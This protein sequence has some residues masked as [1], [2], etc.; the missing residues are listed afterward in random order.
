MTDNPEI[1]S[2]NP[3]ITKILKHFP[4]YMGDIL[5][6]EACSNRMRNVKAKWQSVRMNTPIENMKI[7]KIRGCRYIVGVKLKYFIL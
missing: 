3:K 1:L 2:K 4:L 7:L 6:G 5:M